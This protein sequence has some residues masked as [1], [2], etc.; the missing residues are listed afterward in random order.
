MAA[1]HGQDVAAARSDGGPG[2][3]SDNRSTLSSDGVGIGEN[4]VSMAAF[5]L[6]P[7][8]YQPRQESSLRL[9]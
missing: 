4:F 5:S 9:R 2:L 7:P 8:G 3:C 6:P 1:A